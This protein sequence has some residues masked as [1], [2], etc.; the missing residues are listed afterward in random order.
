MGDLS[1]VSIGLQANMRACMNVCARSQPHLCSIRYQ[2]S[3]EGTLSCNL[4]PE[5]GCYWLK[6]TD[7]EVDESYMEKRKK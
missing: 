3:V 2:E 4:D 6:A 5:E 1:A 7:P